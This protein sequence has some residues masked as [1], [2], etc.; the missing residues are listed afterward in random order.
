MLRKDLFVSYS[1]DFPEVSAGCLASMICSVG[2]KSPVFSFQ[3]ECVWSLDLDWIK[4]WTTW[5]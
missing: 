3:G 2:E 1:G 4:L 5:L